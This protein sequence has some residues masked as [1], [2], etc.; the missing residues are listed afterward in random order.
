MNQLIAFN[1]F[2]LISIVFQLYFNLFQNEN[3]T[4]TL[5]LVVVNKMKNLS[6]Q[7]K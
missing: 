2:L 5:K 7:V 1:I 3:I 4:F 6:N